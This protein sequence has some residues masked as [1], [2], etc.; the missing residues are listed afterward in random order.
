MAVATFEAMNL[1]DL[2]AKAGLNPRAVRFY[3]QRGLLPPPAG[4][5]RGRHYSREHLDTLG[6]IQ[7]L[8]AAGHSLDAIGRILSGHNVETVPPAPEP[9]RPRPTLSAE[10]WTR[11]KLIPGVELHFDATRHQPDV[12]QLLAVREAIRAAFATEDDADPTQ[13]ATADERSEL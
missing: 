9:S 10:L 12:A 2:A 5:G 6:R 3:I 4:L 11:L 8:Q 13:T 7:E 1:A